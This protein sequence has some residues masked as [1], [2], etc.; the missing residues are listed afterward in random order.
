MI[1]VVSAKDHEKKCEKKT[2]S[3]FVKHAYVSLVEFGR[4]AIK[5]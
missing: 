3:I 2:E 5:A 4:Q 1:L